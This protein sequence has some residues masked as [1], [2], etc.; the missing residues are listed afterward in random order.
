M[1]KRSKLIIISGPSGVGKTAVAK[2]L[3]K[4]RDNLEKV[5]TCTSRGARPQEVSGRDYY[6]ISAKEFEHKI[7]KNDFLEY[8]QVHGDYYG[9]PKEE[10]DGILHVGKSPILVID[11]QGALQIKER[12]DKDDCI[13]IFLLPESKEQLKKRIAKRNQVM[14]AAELET[15]MKTAEKEFKH[16]DDYDY[17]VV[18]KEGCWN[19]GYG[20]PDK[21]EKDSKDE[22]EKEGIEILHK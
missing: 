11:V 14:P 17:Q 3:L 2:E 6:F 7:K 10:V 9:T 20:L 1:N 8:A 12:L 18:N 4:K 5:V 19:C 15:R 16:A 22:E 21:A 13:F